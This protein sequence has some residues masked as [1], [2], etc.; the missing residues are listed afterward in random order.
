M[1]LDKGT[2]R[3][4]RQIIETVSQLVE[5]S[6]LNVTPLL[7]L[8]RGGRWLGTFVSFH[9]GEFQDNLLEWYMV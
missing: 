9:F 3:V 1:L 6:I 5:R 4:K 7:H 2:R 8:L